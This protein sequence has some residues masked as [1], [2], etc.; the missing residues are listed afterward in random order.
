MF[1][2]KTVTI[3]LLRDLQDKQSWVL[4]MYQNERLAKVTTEMVIIVPHIRAIKI[5][6]YAHQDLNLNMKIEKPGA[7]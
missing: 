2:L 3:E 5:L 7:L 6:L 1:P 4:W